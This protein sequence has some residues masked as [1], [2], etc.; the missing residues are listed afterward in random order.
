VQKIRIWSRTS[1][2][3]SARDYWTH[4]GPEEAVG[5]SARTRQLST[6]K[7]AIHYENILK[8]SRRHR[9]VRPR[10]S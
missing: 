1:H 6:V 8:L 3:R 2:C 10:Q 5:Y 4:T 9:R 7:S